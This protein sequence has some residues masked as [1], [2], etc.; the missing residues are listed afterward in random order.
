MTNKKDKLI[1]TFESFGNQFKKRTDFQENIHSKEKKTNKTQKCFT[2]AK[3]TLPLS[4]V[5][6]AVP[7][8]ISQGESP[9][10]GG[11]SWEGGAEVSVGVGIPEEDEA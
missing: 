7:G 8:F 1:S 3:N 10:G 2:E 11:V 5:P 9:G 4:L 6:L